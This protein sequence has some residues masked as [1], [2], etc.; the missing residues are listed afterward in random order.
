ME[1][2]KILKYA[3]W[4]CIISFCV[5]EIL[6]FFSRLRHYED[7]GIFYII[8]R[9]VLPII[10]MIPIIIALLMNKPEVSLISIVLFIVMTILFDLNGLSFINIKLFFHIIFYVIYELSFHIMLCLCTFICY[11]KNVLS[12]KRTLKTKNNNNNTNTKIDK[13]QKINTLLEKGIITKEEFEMK[14]RE[15]LEM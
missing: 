5:Y 14:K 2:K 6:L 7:F 11:D 9:S 12:I 4:A 1:I 13:L 10:L 15:I 3:I 8:R